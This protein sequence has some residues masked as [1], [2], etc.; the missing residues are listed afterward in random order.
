M[1]KGMEMTRPERQAYAAR[2]GYCPS[3]VRF[4]EDLANGCHVPLEADKATDKL[5]EILTKKIQDKK[6]QLAKMMKDGSGDHEVIERTKKK[7]A[8]LITELQSIDDV[9]I[10]Q[11]EIFNK[12]GELRSMVSCC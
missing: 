1:E 10:I 9:S 7:L 8:T 6:N 5:R 3:S 2:G 12:E 11:R 4:L